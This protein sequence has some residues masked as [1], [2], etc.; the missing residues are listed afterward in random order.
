MSLLGDPRRLMLRL[1]R[2]AATTVLAVVAGFGGWLFGPAEP[3]AAS[4]SA[5]LP[6]IS[7]WVAD[8]VAGQPLPD[9]RRA[10]PAQIARFFVGLEPAA[11][12]ALAE[13]YPAIVGNLDGAPLDLR[14]AANARRSAWSPER[15]LI[16]YDPRGNGRVAEVL[17]DLASADRIAVIV[18]GLSNRL[19]NFDR[20]CAGR[21]RR[22][23]AWQARQ[24]FQQVRAD[25]GN[26]RVAVIAWLGYDPPEGIGREAAREERARDGAAALVRFVAGL[27][28]YRPMATV[29]LVGHSYGSVVAGLAAP[30]LGR[31]VQDIV[32]LGSPG[33]GVERATELRTSAR[34]WA[35]STLSDWTRELP[36]IRILGAGHGTL[37]FDAAFGARRLPV[38]NVVE[39]DGYFVPGSD[40]LRAVARIVLG[41]STGAARD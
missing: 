19:G 6:G 17:G 10:T 13:R 16:A 15:H 1:T 38:D 41:G 3:A 18:P 31:H 9:P 22:A 7:A 21:E 32:A 12:A 23:L 8:R 4:A 34:V 2:D 35:G 25:D 5:N 27:G 33:M 39:H 11:R 26:A 29:T 28:E 37:P 20:G 40:S 14:F 24:L 30:A 36:G